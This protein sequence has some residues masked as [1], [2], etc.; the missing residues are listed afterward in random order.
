M[1]NLFL[2]FGTGPSPSILKSHL[3]PVVPHFT[4]RDKECADIIDHLKTRDTKFV[5]A[6]GS[7]GF[8]KTSVATAVG[9]QLDLQGLPVLLLSLRGVKTVNEMA[10]QMLNMSQQANQRS[11]DQTPPTDR[12]LQWVS[13]VSS[14]LLLFFDNA[15]DLLEAQ[16]EKFLQFLQNIIKSC[17]TVKLLCTTRASLEYVQHLFDTFVIRIPP[18]DKSSSRKLMRAFLPNVTDSDSETIGQ[19][20]GNVPLAI[21]LVCSMLNDGDLSLED[22]ASTT[23]VKIL[24]AV[25]MPDYPDDLRLKVL[26]EQCFHSLPH[27]EQKA[28]V[29][30][31][32]FNGSFDVPGAAAILG[33][34]EKLASQRVLG[35][36]KRKSLL[37]NTTDSKYSIH[38]LLQ[39]FG[40]M[41]G[42]GKMKTIFQDAN[43]RFYGYFLDVF[44][45]LNEQFHAGQS[46]KAYWQFQKKQQNILQVLERIKNEDAHVLSQADVFLCSIYW[47]DGATYY[48][49][50]DAAISASQQHQDTLNQSQLLV[51]KAFGSLPS[52]SGESTGLLSEAQK[53]QDSLQSVPA[54]IKGKLQ[55][56]QGID[57]VLRGK[58]EEG[59]KLLKNGYCLLQNNP[60]NLSI[61]VLTFQILA[62][63]DRDVPDSLEAFD[64]LIH[65]QDEKEVPYVLGFSSFICGDNSELS[66][67]ALKED[68]PFVLEI[69]YLLGLVCKS[70]TALKGKQRLEEYVLKIQ[71]EM[72]ESFGQEVHLNPLYTTASTILYHLGCYEEALK[73]QNETLA[74][75][76]Q[77]LGDQHVDTARSLHELGCTQYRLE[78]YQNALQSHKEALAI[79][80]QILGDQ[81]VDTAWSLHSL[82]CTQYKLEDYQNALQSHKEALAIRKQILGD[83][84]VDTAWS[85][86]SLGQTQY[87]LD[88]YQNALQSHK[89]ALAIRK[90][91]LGDQ[92]VDTAMSLHSLGCTQ[93]KLGDLMHALESFHK[94]LELRLK[95]L[96][97]HEHTVLTYDWLAGTLDALHRHDCA[98]E[99][100]EKSQ[101]MRRRLREQLTG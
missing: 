18:L 65:A 72:K 39:S 89:E 2:S 17:K 35:V 94:A 13:S 10:R 19:I 68:H 38:P 64:K 88:D 40:E 101:E 26:F 100:R 53:L 25:D 30:L 84:H 21:R 60:V 48:K 44:N 27:D 75:L 6:W 78:N 55:C 28:F 93:H 41:I 1:L 37:E 43:V 52:G 86:Y 33:L 42:S 81:H 50:F 12:V 34:T 70:Q 80:K 62:L 63:C 16:K 4:G 7:P 54:E 73:S 36:L 79:R 15:D 85:L 74:I 96:D 14:P 91:I 3:P 49:I 5:N 8:G 87:E 22:L 51:A 47:N 45:K 76:K 99:T 20:S 90:Q 82:G 59:V 71:R 66:A 11:L 29:C 98:H 24:E 83:Q 67:K 77:I 97:D 32:V 9:H 92:H 46:L 31:S 69:V 23:K 56:Y 61:K 95:L 57:S 58:T